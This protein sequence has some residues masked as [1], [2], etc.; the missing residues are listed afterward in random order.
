MTDKGMQRKRA[1][2][3]GGID[4]AAEDR[5]IG[6]MDDRIAQPRQ[7]R[8]QRD[9]PVFGREPHPRD[10]QRHQRGADDQE[11]ARAVAVDQ[12]A[13]RRLDH[14]RRPGHQRHRQPELGVGHAKG[15]LPHDEHRRQAQLVVM[16]Q[17]MA[18]A[19]QGIDPAVAAQGRQSQHQ[20]RAASRSGG[21]D[22]PI[23]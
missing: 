2:D 17:E 4:R 22:R 10:R 18:A 6:G 16:R 1:A 21:Q 9:L 14:G 7:H 23:L 15:L 19:D 11:A 8:Q 5:V 3:A 20:G 12:K 13:D